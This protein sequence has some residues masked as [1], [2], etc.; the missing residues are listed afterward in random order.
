M[1]RTLL[2]AAAAVLGLSS[3]IAT[4]Q[5][6]A[7]QPLTLERVF[8]APSL[9]GPVPR[10]VKLSPDGRLATL[11]RN[12]PDDVERY[13]LWAIDPATGQMR[14]LVDSQK[15]GSGAALSEAARMQQERARTAGIKGIVSYD[16]SPDGKA[17]WCRWTATSTSPRWT[18]RSAG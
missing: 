8:A 1:N 10:M 18:G 17:S 7:P 13:D 12:R 6:Q 16:W 2:L 14:M 3:T 9:S 5:A 11:L 4:A 15:V